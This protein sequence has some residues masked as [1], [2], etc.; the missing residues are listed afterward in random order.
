[1]NET[2]RAS[3]NETLGFRTALPILMTVV[4]ELEIGNEETEYALGQ[5][6]G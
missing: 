4:V 6:A 1:M 5:S 2:D 3:Q